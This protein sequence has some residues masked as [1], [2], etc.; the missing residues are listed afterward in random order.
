M[1]GSSLAPVPGSAL[2]VGDPHAVGAG[3]S[4]RITAAFVFVVGGDVPDCFMEAGAVVMDP[5]SFELGGEHGRV[6]DR[7]Q[8]GVF[9]FDVPPE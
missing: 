2:F 4:D 7:H 6:G 1:S 9:A 3:G 5:D 8:V